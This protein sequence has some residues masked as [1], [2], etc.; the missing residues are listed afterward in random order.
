MMM[1]MMILQVSIFH[2]NF[3]WDD[4]QAA[5]SILLVASPPTEPL[6]PLTGLNQ[7]KWG[8][9]QHGDLPERC[10]VFQNLGAQHHLSR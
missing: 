6:G 3:I 7:Q 10:L 9:K 5:V 8:C 1:M 4:D 2:P